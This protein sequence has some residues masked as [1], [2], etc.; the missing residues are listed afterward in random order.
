[1]LVGLLITTI[2]QIC[3]VYHHP[4]GTHHLFNLQARPKSRD[5]LPGAIDQGAGHWCWCRRLRFGSLEA[6]WPLWPG[7]WLENP[8]DGGPLTVYITPPV[9]AL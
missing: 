6:T 5:I 9:G 1:M 8:W 3:K 7:A 4:K 2:F